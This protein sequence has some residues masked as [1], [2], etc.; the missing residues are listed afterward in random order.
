ML[1]ANNTTDQ[2]S[3]TI[4]S[5]LTTT[6]PCK[7]RKCVKDSVV[8]NVT[9]MH[10]TKKPSQT[11]KVKTLSRKNKKFIQS[12]CMITD[13]ENVIGPNRTVWPE[14]RYYKLM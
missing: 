13:V 2:S 12:D 8:K 14:Y 9:G 3:N 6:N 7:K 10:T 4:E 11:R 5:E 1:D